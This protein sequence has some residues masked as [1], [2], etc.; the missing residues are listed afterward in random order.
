MTK[1]FNIFIA[2]V[3]LAAISCT[4]D[5]TNDC[6]TTTNE[7]TTSLSLSLNSFRT[8][9]GEKIDGEY[10]L[11]W[12]ENDKISINGVASEALTTQL[13]ANTPNATFIFNQ[14]EFQ[15]PYFIAYPATHTNN[16][17]TF[18]AAQT[19]KDNSSFG[20]NAAVMYGYGN[21]LNGITLEHL[22]TILRIGIKGTATLSNVR[23][24]T[25]DRKPIAGDFEVTFE[26]DEESGETK[27]ELTPTDSATEL[28]T[29]SFADEG[30][31]L[32]EEEIT[33]IHI[34][35][36]AGT[37]K[38]LYV[39]FEDTEFGSMSKIVNADSTKPL[40]AGYVREF[41]EI[42][43]YKA[44]D[45]IEAISISSYETLC[46]FKQAVEA[47]SQLDAI[48]IKDFEMPTDSNENPWT[49]I[50]APEYKGTFSGGG[51]EISGLKAPLFDSVAAT[52]KGV[53][54][55]N[56]AIEKEYI[57]QN[58]GALVNTYLGTS[59]THC[60]VAGYINLVRVTGV[61]NKVGGMVGS[62][63]NFMNNWTISDCENNCSITMETRLSTATDEEGNALAQV[64]TAVGGII[65]DSY[66]ERHTGVSPII[67]NS[68]NNG[69]IKIKG[70]TGS[71]LFVGGIISRLHNYRVSV[72][73]CHNANN[74]A[75]ELGTSESIDVAGIAARFVM[76]TSAPIKHGFTA[77]NCSNSGNISVK[78]SGD[79]S[80]TGYANVAGCFGYLQHTNTANI[81]VDNC[82]NSGDISL[83]S[84]GT[85]T[86]QYHLGGI[87]GCLYGRIEVM[88]CE[89]TG[90]SIKFEANTVKHRTCV[91]GIVGRFAS[92]SGYP[93]S[94]DYNIMY[95]IKCQNKADIAFNITNT[96]SHQ[97][98]IGG[99]AGLAYG[100]GATM[101]TF[102]FEE[103]TNDGGITVSSNGW[104]MLTSSDWDSEEKKAPVTFVGGIIGSN[105]V[106]SGSATEAYQSPFHVVNCKNGETING[107]SIKITGTNNHSVSVG[108]II[109]FNTYSNE[110][111]FKIENCENNMMLE[112]DSATKSSAH[113][114]FGGLV[115]WSSHIDTNNDLVINSSAN[116]GDIKVNAASESTA[117]NVR[118]GGILGSQ[119][120]HYNKVIAVTLNSV[121]NSGN[122]TVGSAEKGFSCANLYI[123]GIVGEMETRSSSSHK[124]NSYKLTDII[125]KGNITVLNMTTTAANYIGG[126][127]GNVTRN[128]DNIKSFCT[129][130]IDENVKA[131]MFAGMPSTIDY[132]L[133]NCGIGGTFVKGSTSATL[134]AVNYQQYIFNDGVKPSS[135]FGVSFLSNPL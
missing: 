92:R 37:Y 130:T 34:A 53:R 64:T 110:K 77:T 5:T 122:I 117:T 19:H 132:K 98:F 18:A 27:I 56:I 74:I 47:G 88:N 8:H 42:V 58:T 101:S 90:K 97:G 14:E 105:W 134:D 129:I 25:I 111:R 65:G 109:G 48:V 71:Y 22:T 62:I 78:L 128:L 16:Q 69:E 133:T 107:K 89:N 10:P 113:L 63:S 44:N 75:I 85:I 116:N 45:A 81:I 112:H 43:E 118:V 2:L 87:V 24:S 12:S 76:G 3:T 125:N 20:G 52:I 121:T 30:K 28:I 35:V 108:G 67:A 114:S 46:K 4:A 59:I 68:T 84:A 96:M 120:S 102:K 29:Y 115:G 49:P 131:G 6:I 36:P 33:Y 66:N 83:T 119:A 54:L 123:G 80:T 104:S 21:D 39:I 73:N 38:E 32:N 95:I 91:G 94:V 11:S 31:Q 82:D 86:C 60:S 124:N 51:F 100:Y 70:N 106:D 23:I 57:S 93:E 79:N 13:G 50:N 9:I 15:A 55:K 126:A 1:V 7:G 135:Y 72:T 26:S 61:A 103:S 17:V 41:N 99:L 40:L 127:V